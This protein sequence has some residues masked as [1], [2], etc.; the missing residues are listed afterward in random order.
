MSKD[1]ET[2]DLRESAEPGELPVDTGP[3][4]QLGTPLEELRGE[5]TA[6]VGKAPVVLPVPSR[7]GYAVRYKTAIDHEALAKWQK[8]SEDRS[9]PDG[10][11]VLGLA[12][13]VLG[14]S[15]EAILRHGEELTHDSRPVTFR[16]ASFVELLG[17]TRPVEACRQ[18]YGRDGHVIA[19]ADEVLRAA[20]YGESLLASGA[21]PTQER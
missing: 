6:E 13:R 16:T 17:V 4:P 18:L 1:R 15:C 20:G 12:L 8:A 9:A 5:L 10:M 21:D 2:F 14:N 11:D 3:E 19:A 7:P